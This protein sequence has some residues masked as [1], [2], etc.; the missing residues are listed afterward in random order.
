M[1]KLQLFLWLAL[2]LVTG[3]FLQGNAYLLSIL[4]FA[5][6][7]SVLAMATTLCMG[8]AGQVTLAQSGFFAI[9]AYASTI[10]T[11]DF[12]APFVVGFLVA[13]IVS[14]ISG[15]LLGYPIMRVKGHFLGLITLAFTQVVHEIALHWETVTGGFNGLFGMT[16]PT[17]PLPGIDPIYSF[18]LILIA[19]W[20]AVLVGADNLVRSRYGR[21]MHMLKA[22]EWGAQACGMNVA[23]YKSDA[24][25]ISA[26]L[27]GG[28]GAFYAAFLGYIGPDTF[29][30]DVS[31]T[32]IA[33]CIF[34]GMTDLRGAIV[35][36]VIL[37]VLNEPLR[38]YPLY[39]PVMYAVVI[40]LVIV[41]LP[42]GVLPSFLRY[43]ET[44]RGRKL[45]AAQPSEGAA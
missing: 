36:S 27:C 24:F 20:F 15:Y 9:G 25:A 4:V 43:L 44:R 35:G 23:Q 5:L 3:F 16:R 30:L 1:S 41:L 26:G 38:N 19:Y 13:L 37:T 8:H 11:L 7:Y 10:M 42:Q 39:Q 18:L 22:S 34:G 2:P 17:L 28:A 31:I 29:T 33:M 12:G 6:I 45:T 32:V 21:A 40:L 14:T